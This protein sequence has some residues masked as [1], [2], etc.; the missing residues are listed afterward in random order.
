MNARQH[1]EDAREVV[2][3][4]WSSGRYVVEDSTSMCGSRHCTVGA[5]VITDPG[6]A[7][8]FMPK[9]PK[10]TAIR[11]RK[12]KQYDEKCRT[13]TEAFDR[14]VAKWSNYG[15]KRESDPWCLL[16]KALCE[17]HPHFQPSDQGRAVE[18]F[19]E[20]CSHMQIVGLFDRAI[21]LAIKEE[22]ASLAVPKVSA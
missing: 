4:S 17:L 8:G 22:A 1:L 6:A 13:W 15:G 12:G 11:R 9:R 21:G 7:V 2:S 10:L 5:L 3:E 20:F 18:T 16:T 19:N 14:E